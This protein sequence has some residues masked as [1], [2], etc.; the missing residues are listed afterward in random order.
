MLFLM[1]SLGRTD[2]KGMKKLLLKN[3][4]QEIIIEISMVVVA[5]RV[6]QCETIKI[7]FN[8]ELYNYFMS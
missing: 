4:A 6:I 1:E 2:N 3:R 7:G 8:Y 5:E